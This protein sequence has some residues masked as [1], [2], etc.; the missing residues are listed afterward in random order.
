MNDRDT[1]R[2]VPALERATHAV[3]LWIDRRFAD[4]RLTQ[5]EAHVL[6]YLAQHAPCSINELHRGFG[7]KRS[8]LTSVLDRLEARDWLRR[9]A[10]PTSRRL[11]LVQLTAS[12][13]AVAEQVSG[14]L[15]GVEERVLARD[16]ADVAAFL[17]VM[18]RLEEELS[19]EPADR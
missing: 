9:A 12:G 10:H 5:A 11:V 19:H 15:H 8:T 2:L 18:R 7:H 6:A 13:R 3:A 1:P 14:A 17:R 4:L 16:G